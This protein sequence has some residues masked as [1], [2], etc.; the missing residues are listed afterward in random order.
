[1]K[2]RVLLEGVKN[3]KDA[4]ERIFFLPEPDIYVSGLVS[5]LNSLLVCLKY[6]QC[7]YN[8]Y[9]GNNNNKEHMMKDKVA[10][11]IHTKK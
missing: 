9:H 8:I 1:M 4:G 6:T 11:F 7:F 3:A 2:K 10:S 5:P